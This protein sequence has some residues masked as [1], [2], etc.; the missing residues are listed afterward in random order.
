MDNATVDLGQSDKCPYQKFPLNDDR[1]RIIKT[2]STYFDISDDSE[3]MSCFVN[4]KYCTMHL[5]IHSLPSKFHQLKNLICDLNNRNIN[6]HFILL[7]ETF[8]V[9]SN[10]ELFHIPG[11]TFL[12]QSRSN[13]SRGGVAMYIADNISFVERPDISINVEGEF[14]SLFIEV[15]GKSNEKDLIVGQIY[16][17]PNTNIKDAISRYDKVLTDIAKTNSYDLIIT[18][19]QNV[20]YMKIE[21]DSNAS[22][23]LDVF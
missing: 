13:I 5:N 18:T 21:N 14:E 12:H 4:A 17:P 16:R 6:I 15:K 10:A 8:L 2:D 23:L 7:C 19:D 22:S 20:D 11:Y 9:E 1:K 3:N